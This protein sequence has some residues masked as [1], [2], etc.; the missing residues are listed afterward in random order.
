M[1]LPADVV[2]G[3]PVAAVDHNSL[4]VRQFRIREEKAAGVSAGGLTAANWTKRDLNTVALNEITGASIS[5]S[6]VITLPAGVFDVDAW[7]PGYGVG[8]HKLRLRQTSGT[9]ADL[10]LGSTEFNANTAVAQTL[11]RLSGRLTLAAGITMEL[12]HNCTTTRAA[13]G[14]GVAAN[15]GVE[16]YSEILIRKVG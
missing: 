8:G 7:A 3:A 5:V 2:T 15:L 16:V 13:S 10:L 9:A 14:A 12:Q 6:S 11:A 4:I 1:G